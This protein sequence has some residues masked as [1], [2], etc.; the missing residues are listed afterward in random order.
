ADAAIVVGDDVPAMLV[1]ILGK[2]RVVAA[3]H[4]GGRIDDGQRARAGVP[5]GMAPLEPAERV[6][7][8]CG[9]LHGTSHPA[10]QQVKRSISPTA[11]PIRRTAHSVRGVKTE[12]WLRRMQ[13]LYFP[14]AEKMLPCAMAMPFSLSMGSS[15]CV[16]KDSG[17][18]IHSVKPPCGWP[19]RVPSGK[20]RLTHS[21]MMSRW[22]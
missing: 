15:A 20:Y 10:P 16:S 1:Q 9:N 5:W 13:F 17:S 11:S 19:I 8:C 12:A 18:S 7:I 21:V 2:A 14:V 22:R 3:A 6:A 4:R